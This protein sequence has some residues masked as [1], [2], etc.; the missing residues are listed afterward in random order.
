M[1]WVKK[2]VPV[3]FETGAAPG[4]C[5]NPH[6]PLDPK[7]GPATCPKQT[8]A[9][10]AP[11]EG[12][13]CR[14][15]TIGAPRPPHKATPSLTPEGQEEEEGEEAVEAALEREEGEEDDEGQ[16]GHG[17]RPSSHQRSP[18]A[19]GSHKNFW[20][21]PKSEQQL[22]SHP[23]THPKTH[24]KTH[25]NT[26]PKTHPKT[27][28][29][30]RANPNPETKSLPNPI[31]PRMPGTEVMCP[32]QIPQPKLSPLP[33]CPRVKTYQP[34]MNSNLRWSLP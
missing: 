24:P 16:E 28:P 25:P 27:H 8:G 2:G 32:P 21:N 22:D 20:T 17:G 18:G 5:A 3:Q 19:R 31:F 6:P 10:D 13:F 29:R 30:P 14:A 4:T 9:P 15:N 26:H 7:T 1:V 34:L 12:V 23:M 11:G 33:P